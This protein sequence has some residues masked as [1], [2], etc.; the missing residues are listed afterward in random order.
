LVD[1][2]QRTSNVRRPNKYSKPKA[3]NTRICQSNFLLQLVV[4]RPWFPILR[5][6]AFLTSHIP[7]P[8]TLDIPHTR[9]NGHPEVIL[10]LWPS[11]FHKL[12]LWLTTHFMQ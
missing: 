12:I 10:I 4:S 9:F 5:H 2:K 1:T 11:M 3:L 8:F 6:S 7:S